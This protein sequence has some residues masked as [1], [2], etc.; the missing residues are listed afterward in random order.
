VTREERDRQLVEE[1]F[2]V[3][4]VPPTPDLAAR[5]RER[6]RRERLRREGTRGPLAVALATGGAVVLLLAGVLVDSGYL[7][8]PIDPRPQPAPSSGTL[9]GQL[10]REVEPTFLLAPRA[11][12]TGLPGLRRL[13]WS[14]RALGSF[15]PSLDTT[16]ASV[17][18]DGSLVA[19]PDTD[20]DGAT[21]LDAT[22]RPVVHL[23]A[24]GAWSSDGAHAVCA[25]QAG[26]APRVT[27]TDLDAAGGA[28]QR[29][30]PVTGDA[31]PDAR[32]R[33][34]GCSARADVAVALRLE[35]HGPGG[36]VVAEATRI[37]P[38]TGRVLSRVD[39]ADRPPLSSPVLSH[40][41]RY[42]AGSVDGGRTAE[43]RDLV[44][45]EVVGHVGGEVVA[46]SGDDQLV[47]VDDEQQGP[48]P[49]AR[50]S[51]VDWRW[52]RTVW[53]DAGRAEPLAVRPRGRD[54][55]VSLTGDGS[56]DAA[57]TLLVTADGRRVIDLDP[58]PSGRP[59][60]G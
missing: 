53:S 34:W 45:G 10:G 55:V 12:E 16:G 28:V 48:V 20:G 24:F 39:F 32:W 17:S 3:T 26:D 14:G 21:V 46:F 8:L 31:L 13:D 6:V 59:L 38:S 27:M 56:D 54:L 15:V 1:A 25:L 30:L 33:L 5:V 23:A 40:G 60:Q 11:G 41:A 57:R 51:L 50:A 7:E 47:L 2:E 9:G 18:P 58:A 4:R 36:E 19:V 52:G 42:L 44:S 43:I 29:L 35:Q 49:A 37:R 22:G